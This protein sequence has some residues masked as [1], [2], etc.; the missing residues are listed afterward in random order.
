[1][2]DFIDLLIMDEAGQVATEIGM[3]GF[4]FAKK[5]LIIGDT[6]QI[7]PVRKF[8]EHQDARLMKQFDLIDAYEDIKDNGLSVVEAVVIP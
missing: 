7:E 1:M 2:Y 5:A 8:G 4:A 3:A 6:D